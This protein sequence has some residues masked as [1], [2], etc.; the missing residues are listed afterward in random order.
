MESMSYVAE[1][2]AW[3]M[4]GLRGPM[5]IPQKP[6]GTLVMPTSGANVDIM[7]KGFVTHTVS[8]QFLVCI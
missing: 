8:I 3:P 7:A 2:N 4:A 6:N 5:N 1:K